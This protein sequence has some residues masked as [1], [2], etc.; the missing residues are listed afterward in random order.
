MKPPDNSGRYLDDLCQWAGLFDGRIRPIDRL[1]A[2]IF[3]NSKNPEAR[4]MAMFT[5]YFDASGT[6]NDPFVV[7]SGYI[8]NFLQWRMLENMWEAIHNEHDVLM[9][10]H[11]TD[12]MAATAAPERYA[13]QSNARADYVA[14]AQDMKKAADFFKNL[15]IAQQSVVNCGVSCIV[16]M[17][18]YNEVSSLLDLRKVIPP[19]AL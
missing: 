18:I 2:A 17:S 4:L 13:K 7:V 12:F 15:C 11:M 8:A 5:G 16:K 10:F 9:P 14:I 1:A 19:Y 3:V 6:P